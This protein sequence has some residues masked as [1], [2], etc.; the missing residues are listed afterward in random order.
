MGRLRGDII[1]GVAGTF[2]VV[3]L[4]A[5]DLAGEFLEGLAFGLGDQ[6]SGEAAA[7]HEEGENLH[8]VVE[9]GR[10]VGLGDMA[11]GSERAEDALRD[12]GAHLARRGRETVR[13]RAVAGREAL[14]GHDEGGGV[15]AEVEE[16]LAQDV[17]GKQTMFAEVVIVESNDNEEDGQDSEA[18]EL[19]RF[20]ADGVDGRHGHPVAG[21]GT[22]ADDDQ[23]ANSGVAEDLIDVVALGVADGLKNDGVV[24]TKAIECNIYRT[25]LVHM[26]RQ[27]H[28]LCQDILPRK[29]QDPAVPRRTFPCLHWP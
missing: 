26:V 3:V 6:K 28:A 18:S 15:G 16:E 29:N 9:P 8:D 10:R 13:G 24:E 14:A 25:V 22:G 7:Q 4:G 12:D 19:D 5:R 17:Q 1:L 20:A 2:G 21:D 11:L 23:V 27:R